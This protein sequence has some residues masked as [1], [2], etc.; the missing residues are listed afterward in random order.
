VLFDPA[1]GR[2]LYA[3]DQDNQWHPA[4]L[5]KIMTAYLVFEALREGKISL[6]DKVNC[7]ELAHSQAPSRLGI[8][9][10]SEITVE[11]ALHALIVKS[12]NDAAIMLAE[13]IG[14]SQEAFVARMNATATRLGMTRTHFVNPNGLPAPEQVSTA[15]DMAKLTV[16]V[17]R[18]F[19]NHAGLWAMPDMRMGKRRLRSH[20]ALL[21]IYE[22]GDGIKTGFICD[23]GFNMVASATRDGKRLAAVVLGEVT[24]RERSA[25]AAN[26][27]EHGFQTYGWRV[28]L[29]G[30]NLSTLPMADDAKGVVSIRH[31][32][33]SWAC[34][35]ARR[36]GRAL[37]RRAKGKKAAAAARKAAARKRNAE[38]PVSKKSQ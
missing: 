33:K 16:A 36:P 35:T 30:D 11:T 12:A 26:L 8:P 22:G 9:V 28:A 14:G 3:E 25:R 18:D 5:T 31:A 19:P 20:N 4:S 34:G 29:G 6:Q 13:A 24:G 15:R 37:A 1:D 21:R 23:S 7:S 2:V 32:V 17:L 38:A 10:G 27:L